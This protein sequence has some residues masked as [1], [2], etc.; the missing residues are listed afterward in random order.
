MLGNYFGKMF[1][2]QSYCSKNRNSLQFVQFILALTGKWWGK[3]GNSEK[4][5]LRD[6]NSLAWNMGAEL[7]TFS[8][9]H[10]KYDSCSPHSPPKHF[11]LLYVPGN[12]HG[13]DL[14]FDFSLYRLLGANRKLLMLFWS[15]SVPWLR[16]CSV[17][18]WSCFLNWTHLLWG[19]NLCG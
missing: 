4:E 1:S 19:T 7:E 2:S 14:K 12:E 5:P 11:K 16:G 13:V 6:H 8:Q 15:G 17:T 18:Q 3:H 10:T 9:N